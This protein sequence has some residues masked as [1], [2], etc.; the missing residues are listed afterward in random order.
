LIGKDD[1]ADAAGDAKFERQLADYKAMVV[2]RQSAGPTIV[3]S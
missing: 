1:V 3:G 2:L